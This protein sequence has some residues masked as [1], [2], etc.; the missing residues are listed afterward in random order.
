V[1]PGQV[2][3]Q[4]RKPRLIIPHFTRCVEIRQGSPHQIGCLR[5]SGEWTPELEEDG[6]QP[7]Y[8]RSPDKRYLILVRWDT[9]GNTPGFRLILIDEKQKSVE[10][11]QR[12]L[13]CCES[14]KWGDDGILWKAFAQL[15]GRVA[16]P[17]NK[18]DP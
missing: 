11:S 1:T 12:I 16:V 2:A 10:S 17:F 3:G 14:L 13:G 4:Q 15:E 18:S 9:P 7:I 6:W 8:A 5:L